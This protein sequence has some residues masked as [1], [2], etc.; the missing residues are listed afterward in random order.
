[1]KTVSAPK[2]GK[3]C[4]PPF[5]PDS[6]RMSAK[7]IQNAYDALA[8]EYEKRIWFDQNVLGVARRRRKLL[9]KASGKILDVACGTGQ[10]FS[11]FRPGSQVT[12]IELSPAMLDQARETAK[13]LGLAISFAIMDAENLQYPDQSFDTVVSTMSTC[14]FPNPIRAL[15]EMKRVTRP[16]GQ[17]LLLE[18]GHS[19][20]KWLANHQDRNVLPHYQKSAGCRWN[21]DPLE[22]AQKAGL[23]I[24]R[25]ERFGLGM[26]HSIEA[27]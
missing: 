7:D 15:Q 14:T 23:E 11:L 21:Q 6:E 4:P 8:P 9:S 20:W 27:V 19:S 18:H 16:G 13:K 1:M 24:L 17:V 22:L 25:A 10:N 26:F 3:S 5:I 12:A 2:Q